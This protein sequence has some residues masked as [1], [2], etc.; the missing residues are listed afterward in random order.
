[1]NQNV[2]Y[3][4]QAFRKGYKVEQTIFENGNEKMYIAFV[5]EVEKTDSC[6]YLIE[7]RE[8]LINNQLPSLVLEQVSDKIGNLFFPLK[9]ETFE[10]GHL[11][12]ITNLEE[13]RKRWKNLKPEFSYYY[14][15]EY[16]QKLIQIIE[17]ELGFKSKIQNRILNSL[18]YRLYFLPFQDYINEKDL[19][20][21]LYLP[22]FPF[23]NKVKYSIKTIEKPELSENGKLHIEMIGSCSD[24]RNFEEI[25][26][27]Q[28][29]V[30]SER[31][32]NICP[33]KIEST[34]QLNL[35]DGSVLS[36]HTEIVLQSEDGKNNRKIVFKLNPI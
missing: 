32:E 21:D 31:C 29:K 10:N 19:Y 30:E 25:I 1:M 6:Q 12:H 16:A 33:G 28:K 27:S 8:I 14:K 7:R 22:I 13:I 35:K 23:R 9:V 34:Y 15:G 4:R 20:F 5:M 36:I 24:S 2:L 11:K 18:F 17:N 3:K 26:N